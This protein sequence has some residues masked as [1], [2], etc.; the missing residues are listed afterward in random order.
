MLKRLVGLDIF[1]EPIITSSNNVLKLV[2]KTTR[3][4]YR[5]IVWKTFSNE[6]LLVLSSVLTFS[7]I[8]N[9]WT[10]KVQIFWHDTPG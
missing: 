5:K 4:V 1:M 8:S 2:V 10:T 9:Q 6:A 3:V 7:L